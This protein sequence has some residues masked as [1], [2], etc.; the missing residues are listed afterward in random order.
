MRHIQVSYNLSI[1]DF[2]CEST[3]DDYLEADSYNLSILDFKS[4]LSKAMQL[5]NIDL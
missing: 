3:D 5:T 1:L 2:K 4:V